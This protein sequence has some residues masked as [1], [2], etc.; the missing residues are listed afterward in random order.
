MKLADLGQKVTKKLSDISAEQMI[1]TA[2]ISVIEGDILQVDW[3]DADIVFCA[4]V[5][6]DNDLKEKIADKFTQ[7]KKGTRILFMSELPE[8]PQI[9][10]VASWKANFSW[11]LN[12]VRQF[13]II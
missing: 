3:S 11:G 9:R 7:L 5:T 8:R 13:V 10:A 4:S 2:P 12:P 1:P 6:W